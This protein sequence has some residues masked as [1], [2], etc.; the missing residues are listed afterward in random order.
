MTEKRKVETIHGEVEYKTVECCSCGNKV[1]KETASYFVVGDKRKKRSRYDYW[2]IDMNSFTDG[3]CCSQ[4]REN[5]PIGFPQPKPSFW[6]RVKW[7][8][9]G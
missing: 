5:G 7:V 9:F 3:W 2:R 4:C 8:L 1:R 6:E